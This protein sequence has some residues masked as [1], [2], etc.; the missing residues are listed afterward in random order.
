M[1]LSKLKIDLFEST[2][3]QTTKGSKVKRSKFGVGKDIG[4]SLYVHKDYIPKVFD[5]MVD[6]AIILLNDVYPD[7]I[8]NLVRIDY[9]KDS[10]GFYDCKEFDKV[11]EPDAG[12]LVVV[13]NGE[14]K[15][16]KFVKQIFHHK[17]LWVSNDYRGFNVG[18][19][20]E[21]SKMWLK[22]DDIPFNKIGRLQA[23]EKYLKTKGIEL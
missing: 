23:W 21:R 16:P 3:L 8:F 7:F 9:K 6:D 19:S 13:S 12:T 2:V 20:I 10:I 1:K 14:V 15:P 22:Y 17:W 11:N 5:D 4:Q 18:E